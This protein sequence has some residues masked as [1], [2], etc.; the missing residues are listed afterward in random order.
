MRRDRETGTV[1]SE[2]RC[3]K[4]RSLCNV[5]AEEF[6]NITVD[7]SCYCDLGVFCRCIPIVHYICPECREKKKK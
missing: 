2:I 7:D 4:C 3:D 5:P 6:E 1:D